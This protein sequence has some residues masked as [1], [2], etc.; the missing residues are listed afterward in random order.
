MCSKKKADDAKQPTSVR[1]QAGL[2]LLLLMALDQDFAQ[3]LQ[4]GRQQLNDDILHCRAGQ[5]R[6]SCAAAVRGPLTCNRLDV[7]LLLILLLQPSFSLQHVTEVGIDFNAHP[8]LAAG[9]LQHAAKGPP[10]RSQPPHEM[11]PWP[12]AH[13]AARLCPALSMQAGLQPAQ[14]LRPAPA[15]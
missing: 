14:A 1:L 10:E 3:A 12:M 13:Q 8:A 7:S 11:S 9:V 4:R 5:G 15:R 6:S 2:G